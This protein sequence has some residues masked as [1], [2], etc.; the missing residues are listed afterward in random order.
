MRKFEFCKTENI[1]KL[2]HKLKTAVC[3]FL[4]VLGKNSV[5]VHQLSTLTNKLDMEK[6]TFIAN[7]YWY[8]LFGLKFFYQVYR[9]LQQ[10]LSSWYNVS[11]VE[12][13]DF[14]SI[15]ISHIHLSVIRQHF[16]IPYP[17]L[18]QETRYQ[19]TIVNMVLTQNRKSNITGSFKKPP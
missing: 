2:K 6:T 4:N 7:F 8:T 5:V 9:C 15:N 16:S 13:V 3:F 17:P 10:F 18:F 11:D 1:Y 19:M 12:D 14:Y